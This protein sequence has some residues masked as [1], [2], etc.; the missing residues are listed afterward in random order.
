[1]FEIHRDVQ[2]ETHE[3]FTRNGLLLVHSKFVKGI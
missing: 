1:M 2:F 3:L